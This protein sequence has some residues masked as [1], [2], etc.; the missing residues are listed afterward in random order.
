MEQLPPFPGFREE[1]FLFLQDLKANN[2]R[3]WFKPRKERFEDEL[4]WPLRCL[5][6]DLSRAF[7]GAGIP[8][9]GDPSGSLFRIYRDVRF[10]KNKDPYKTHVA[11]VLSRTGSRKESGGLYIHV[12]PG[13]CFVAGGFWQP[14][15]KLLQAWRTRMAQ[16]PDE[17]RGIMDPLHH[18]GFELASYQGVLKRLPR[19]FESVEDPRIAGY[20]KHKSLILS[21][22]FEDA[23]LRNSGF[24][25]DVVETVQ[26]MMPLLRWGWGLQTGGKG[27]GQA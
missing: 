22:A 13:G 15:K 5:V 2:E 10:S 8:L 23:R 17:I 7:A 14:D 19:G 16:E 18:A 26:T 3:D 9:K 11:A 4:I 6:A 25:G 20:L 27:R 12:E 24:T 1:A 21:R